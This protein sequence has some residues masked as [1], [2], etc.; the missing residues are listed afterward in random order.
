MDIDVWNIPCT[1]IVGKKSL[2]LRIPQLMPVKRRGFNRSDNSRVAIY[3]D[4]DKLT[5]TSEPIN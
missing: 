2:I 5:V 1:Q 3:L 4:I